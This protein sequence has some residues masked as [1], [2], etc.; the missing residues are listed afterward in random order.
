MDGWLTTLLV[1]RNSY[2]LR[3]PMAVEVHPALADHWIGLVDVVQALKLKLGIQLRPVTLCC[4]CA[5][6]QA[7]L[8]SRSVHDVTLYQP[9]RYAII[10]IIATR[11]QFQMRI[12]NI[13]V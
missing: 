9:R 3:I 10:I 2:P 8:H 4:A 5:Q 11:L 6:L 7:N 12:Q 13:T 1:A